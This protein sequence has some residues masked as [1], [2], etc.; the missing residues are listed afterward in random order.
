MK[1]IIAITL[2][3][4]L[5][6]Q[7]LLCVS[8]AS[9]QNDY[10]TEKAQFLKTV[11]VMPVIPGNYDAYVSRAEFSMY[12]ARIAGVSEYGTTSQRRLFIDIP[13]DHWAVFAINGLVD[14][15][16]ISSSFDGK[17]RPDD[18]IT[19][20]EAAKILVSTL[21][22]E[23]YATA[24]GGF[25]AGYMKVAKQ[26]GIISSD[27]LTANVTY[28]DA[29]NMLYEAVN[30]GMLD[31]MIY[32]D[33]YVQYTH[34]D[35]D[36]PLAIYKNIH[37]TEGVVTAVDGIS[38]NPDYYADF[39]EI[40]VNGETYN[41]A[42]D[43]FEYIGRYVTL[44][45]EKTHNKHHNT[46]F[47][48]ID[49]IKNNVVEFDA[50][51]FDEYD[52]KNG[53]IKYFKGGDK[54]TSVKITTGIGVIKNGDTVSRNIENTIKSVK[55]G[56]FALIDND[57]DK[58]YELLVISEYRNIAVSYVDTVKN[59]IY[60]E[61][62]PSSPLDIQS[63]GSKKVI[64]QKGEEIA[65]IADISADNI[66]TVYESEKYIRIYVCDTSVSG[67]VTS[68]SKKAD[69]TIL[70]IDG[71]T[72]EV[73]KDFLLMSPKDIKSGT[74]GTFMTD[75]FGKI[76]HMS[77]DGLNISGICAYVIDYA[78]KQGMDSFAMI[79]L[80]VPSVGIKEYTLSEKVRI[81]GE[82]ERGAEKKISL[83]NRFNGD[84]RGQVIFFKDKDGIISY[85]DTP[86]YNEDTESDYSLKSNRNDS[87]V[88][89]RQKKFGKNIIVND[90][91]IVMG[92]PS[93]AELQ[94]ATDIDFSTPALS[95]IS[96][97]TDYPVNSYKFDLESGFDNVVVIKD[98]VSASPTTELVMVND[99]YS[100]YNGDEAVECLSYF[101]GGGFNETFIDGDKS[102]LNDG[103]KQGDVLRIGI[104]S[105]GEISNW[106]V[107][108]SYKKDAAASDVNEVNYSSLFNTTDRV[109]FGYA[110]SKNDGVLKLYR[111]KNKPEEIDE[112]FDVKEITMT[113][114]DSSE[115]KEEN[116][117]RSG[118]YNEIT[119]EDT[120]GNPAMIIVRTNLAQIKEVLVFK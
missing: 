36:T 29:V 101:G 106:K 110:K 58:I 47:I 118:N 35:E 103:I 40:F 11:G 37:K 120:V 24:Y 74:E 41:F 25:P 69:K 17:F 26:T 31:G 112:V 83:L 14:K 21:G 9:E 62:N 85:I 63:D 28:K 1:R 34:S 94:N 89:Y 50:E 12:T 20:Q 61:Y 51:D 39:G 55:K 81:D 57:R 78:T 116:R 10:I 72:Y 104:N 6:F 77:T 52:Q 93:D 45:Y 46:V 100:S 49:N 33:N 18:T 27:I 53:V 97:N 71:N 95:N 91:T 60:D 65:E 68:V 119:T 4:L 117:I 59:K 80:F 13:L 30:T 88:R 105:K 5:L 38:I 2:C 7:S 109:I 79:R 107:I 76:A 64:I 56:K 54:S 115:T 111:D 99:I 92:V 44:Y 22:Y 3:F 96:I 75:K 114:Y 16:I 15:G 108:F 48:M 73:D 90:Q 84:I 66:L 87:G 8:Y 67:K 23:A 113:I 82:N 19:V 102:M 43:P 32:S 70:T 42:G 86:Y 98:F